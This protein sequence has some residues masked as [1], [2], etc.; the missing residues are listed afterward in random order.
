MDSKNHSYEFR[1]SIIEDSQIHMEWLK[2]ELLED[3]RFHV[4]S[5]DF[6][7][8]QGLESIKLHKPDLVLLDFQLKDM[9]GLEVSKRIKNYE[10]NTKVFTL[11]AH[12][13]ISILER[14]INDKSIDAI[15][16][17]GSPYF[18]NNFIASIEN[19]IKGG[20]Y[21]D[22]S[23]LKK[24]REIK[25]SHGLRQLTKR[26]FEVFIQANIGKTDS[27]IA[28]DLSVEESHIKNLKS[29]IA[30]KIKDDN[31]NSLLLKLMKNANPDALMD[32]LVSSD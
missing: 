27:Q 28:E 9:T 16:V 21:L 23:L 20:T 11:T 3:C 32:R 4:V 18:E 17:K 8:R 31:V 13:E 14:I 1:I 19:V 26:E 7:G 2:Q 30:K 12:T 24:L 10:P 22:P 25:I 29:R 15:A 5:A 6:L